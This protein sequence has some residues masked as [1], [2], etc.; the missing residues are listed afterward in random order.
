M[1]TL[2]LHKLDRLPEL[3]RLQEEK[4][5]RAK[6]ALSKIDVFAKLEYVPTPRQQLFHDADEFDVLFGGSAG[7]GKTRA[8]L[9]DDIRD[10]I[11]HPGIR[12]GAF[13]RTYGELKE[14]LLAELAL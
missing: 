6:A 13:R 1:S 3:R 11:R 10:A 5:R 8:L 7:G 12:I 4:Q 2:D 9:M 14:S